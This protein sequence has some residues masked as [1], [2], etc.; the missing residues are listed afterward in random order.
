MTPALLE[1][2]KGFEVFAE[3][4]E[5]IVEEVKK[6]HLKDD[7]GN[8]YDFKDFDLRDDK[9]GMIDTMPS[10]L[11]DYLSLWRYVQERFNDY[12]LDGKEY[13]YF[14][15]YWND[16]KA[17]SAYFDDLTLWIYFDSEFGIYYDTD[18]DIIEKINERDEN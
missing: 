1:Q 3:K 6:N 11:E 2:F 10:T 13:M 18:T 7:K 4:M 17:N 15:V 9:I 8:T 16:A 12:L 5:S 14:D